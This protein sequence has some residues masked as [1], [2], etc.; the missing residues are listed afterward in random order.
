MNKKYK[1]G[2]CGWENFKWIPQMLPPNTDWCAV[3]CTK[4]K[5]VLLADYTD[6]FINYVG[7]NPKSEKVLVEEKENERLFR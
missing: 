2:Y 5:T 4:C 6:D 7:Y 1:C 3:Q